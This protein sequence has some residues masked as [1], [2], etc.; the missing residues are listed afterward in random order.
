M[1]DF[2]IGQNPTM[3]KAWEKAEEA[4]QSELNVLLQGETG[5]GKNLMA[6]YIHR[7][8]R[9]AN[10]HM[11]RLDCSIFSLNLV[12]SEL[13]G[14][15][16][17]AFTGAN[18]QKQGLLELAHNNTLFLDEVGNI[19][20]QVQT[21]LL[22]VLDQGRFRRVGG[23]KEIK[24]DFRLISATNC[25][26][27]QMIREGGFRED[28]YHRLRGME[29]YLP[30]LRERREDILPLVD[31]YLEKYCREYGREVT[32]SEGAREMFLRYLW[33]GNVREL[34]R[35]IERL[36]AS[37]AEGVIGPDKLPL[38]VLTGDIEMKRKEERPLTLKE[39]ER[40]HILKTFY[41]TGQ[42]RK[43][44]ARLLGISLNTLKAKL[45]SYGV[46]N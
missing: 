24:V 12:E 32:F 16:K 28:L 1:Q 34:M 21:K 13:F 38:E 18:Y 22:G 11:M 36:I 35:M 40:E 3:Q 9:R 15:E 42:N 31:F 39:M 30:P 25:D 27:R 26:L 17:G 2:V 23:T 46:K 8:S 45:R 29:I 33:P 7:E 5:T 4:S 20:F 44:T 10:R 41:Q 37:G 14:H 6:E 43:K 19:P